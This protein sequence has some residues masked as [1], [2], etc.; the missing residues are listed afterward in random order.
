MANEELLRDWLRRIQSE[1]FEMPGLRLTKPQARR[2]WSLDPQF[3]DS[4]LDTLVSTHVLEKGPQG[5]YVLAGKTE[6]RRA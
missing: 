5:V 3:C 6:R 4:L 2:L 1:F